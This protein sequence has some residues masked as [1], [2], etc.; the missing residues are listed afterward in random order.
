[1][2][3]D[4][5]FGETIREWAETAR[6]QEALVFLGGSGADV[7]V[8]RLT[9]GEL[10]RAAAALAG[11][12]REH[13]PVGQRVLLV[14]PSPRLFAVSM[15]ACMYAGAIAV[16]VAVPGASHH[17]AD[18][19]LGVI[20]DSSAGVVLT[21]AA[22]APEVSVLLARHGHSRISCL[23]VESLPDGDG[24]RTPLA[25]ADAPAL[26]QYTSGPATKPRGVVMT[27]RNLLAGQQAL[28]S[29]LDTR[30]GD[31]VGGWLP[32]HHGMG[33][34]GQL[35][36]PLWLGGT[37]VLLSPSV[38]TRRPAAWLQ[39]IATHRL[40]VSAGPGSA[41][42]LCVRQIG[43]QELAGLD[44]SG[45]EKA[46]TAP[47]AVR[48]ETLRA[49]ADR[50]AVA[51]FRP[52]AFRS[53][54]GPSEVPVLASGR[55]AGGEAAHRVVDVA[56]LDHRELRDPVP[57]R[58][59]RA[60]ADCGTPVGAELLIVDPVSRG[61]LPDGRTGEIWIRGP[62]VAQGYWNRPWETRE[63]F[64]A[65]TSDGAHGFLR[66]GD[67][68]AVANGRLYVTG[69][70][71][72]AVALADRPLSPGDLERAVRQVSELFG[73]GAAF[74]VGAERE[75]VVV[76]LELR[77]KGHYNVDLPALVSSVLERLA[78]EFQLAP[79][80][81]FLVRSGTIRRTSG[82]PAKPGELR[83]LL[84]GG[85]LKVIHQLVGRG[86]R[87]LIGARSA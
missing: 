48:P 9:Y 65:R 25:D 7:P 73:A 33:L 11:W 70:L 21:D 37:G 86:L 14:Q 56:A 5:P 66:T 2:K 12:L 72:D 16:P 51:G 50:F 74:G 23:A 10:D 87:E 71:E 15:L 69:R 36:H 32:V 76:V 13:G 31:R 29:A 43:E 57:G 77:G 59:T 22:T 64:D 27:H 83:R 62:A 28:S 85:E 42:D 52:D 3:T 8:E 38:F 61:V 44:V 26:V 35:L 20:R 46:V 53:C 17:R 45:W 60:L 80:G 40:R 67:V 49:F 39:A 34:V 6:H 75:H 41:Y 82:A 47:G 58:P 68:G 24:P 63:T 79:E 84:L 18:R 81:V 1:M 4:R 19:V 30:P 78:E 54:Y 55:V